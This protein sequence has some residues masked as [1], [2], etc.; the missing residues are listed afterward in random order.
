M[1]VLL[2]Q[3]ECE[4]LCVLQLDAVKRR[5]KDVPLSAFYCFI[6]NH[7]H[8][9]CALS[10]STQKVSILRWGIIKCIINVIILITFLLLLL[11][12]YCGFYHC[13]CIRGVG[14]LFTF[15]S[16]VIA[17]KTVEEYGAQATS[18]TEVFSSKVK[19]GDLWETCIDM[20]EEYV[21]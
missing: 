1:Y 10:G 14:W 20:Y 21:R 11:L 15:L 8:E 17:A 9:K 12:S 13:V 5:W 6:S 3:A 16:V 4:C 19:M 18:V 2:A 7:Y